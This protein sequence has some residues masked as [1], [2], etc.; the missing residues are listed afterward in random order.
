MAL[1]KLNSQA[2]HGTGNGGNLSDLN[3]KASHGST[4]KSGMA[5][6]LLSGTRKT[7]KSPFPSMGRGPLRKG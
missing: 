7:G 1:G 5:A 4:Q 6:K 3:K 2:S